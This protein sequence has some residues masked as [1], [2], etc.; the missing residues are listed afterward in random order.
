MDR[1]AQH[2]DSRQTQG[3]TFMRFAV[4][5]PRGVGL[6]TR[7][8]ITDLFWGL[9]RRR[10]TEPRSYAPS[11]PAG[12]TRADATIWRPE[13][14][15][16]RLHEAGIRNTGRAVHLLRLAVSMALAER[17]AREAAAEDQRRRASYAAPQRTYMPTS[18]ATAVDRSAMARSIA[19]K[20]VRRP[21]TPIRRTWLQ[22]VGFVN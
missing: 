20:Y 3:V 12:A 5:L 1:I 7:H 18:S 6:G 19:R 21:I 10:V 17:A 4:P 2:L 8:R 16:D 9:V 13:Y 22:G 15:A 11:L 14:R